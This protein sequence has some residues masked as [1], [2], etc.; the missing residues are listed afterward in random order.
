MGDVLA[1]DADRAGGRL[2]QLAAACGRP[3]TCRSRSRRPGPASRRGRSRTTRRRPRRPG[4]RRGENTPLWI[5]KCFLRSVTSSNLSRVGPAFMPRPAAAG[6]RASRRPRCAGPMLLA[7]AAYAARH[8]S[9][10]RL[11]RGAKLQPAGRL[12]S[13]GTMPLISFSRVRRAVAARRVVEMRDR[14]EQALGVGMA[15]IV[16]QLV[17]GGLLDL[18]AG[19]HHHDPVGV[20]G[21]HAH[22]VGDQDDGGAERLLQL[23]HQVEDLRLDGDVERGGRLVGDQHLGIARQRHGDHHALAHAAGELVRIG[24]GALLRLRG[25]GRGAASRRPCPSASRATGPGA[26]R[27][28]R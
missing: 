12:N 7:A 8:W 13:D 5:G 25:S 4:R 19:I 23:A 21:D 3:S 9:V 27:S 26:A 28:P 6:R 14:A 15:G 17:G 10:A 22:V 20:L 1:A 11:Q 18:A 2:E 16:E 24:V